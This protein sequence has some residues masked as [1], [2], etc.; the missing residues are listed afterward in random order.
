VTT[1]KLSESEPAYK[2][3]V[4][5]LLLEHI[6]GLARA[7]VVREHIGP[8]IVRGVETAPRAEWLPAAWGMQ[9]YDSI[10]ATLGERHAAAVATD[11]VLKAPSRP[12]FQPL[13]RGVMHFFGRRPVDLLRTYPLAQRFNSRHAG[14]FTV[15][16][17]EPTLVRARSLPQELRRPVWPV[18]QVA[19]IEATLRLGGGAGKVVVDDGEFVSS[20]AVDF[21]V[22][23]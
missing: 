15:A 12:I 18:V 10:A 20:G 19:V 6:D 17:G 14:V 5:K 1:P 4:L 11:M 21:L 23:T 3:G 7:A 16:V 2:A 9:L 22:Q 13:L 8:A